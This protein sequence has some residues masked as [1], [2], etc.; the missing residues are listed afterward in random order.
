MRDY[1]Q[2]FC[3]RWRWRF[4]VARLGITVTP[5]FFDACFLSRPTRWCSRISSCSRIIASV[6]A[7]AQMLA[8]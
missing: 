1:A 3:V 8:A 2:P 6:S 7:G 5:V 4:T